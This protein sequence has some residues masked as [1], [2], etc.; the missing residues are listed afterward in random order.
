MSGCEN[1]KYEDIQEEHT[2]I[3]SIYKTDSNPIQIVYSTN[4]NS[5]D[6]SKII[7]DDLKAEFSSGRFFNNEYRFPF[8][9]GTYDIILE[10]HV[11]DTIDR[12][13]WIVL[14]RTVKNYTIEGDVIFIGA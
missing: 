12:D 11:F 10:H 14:S 1:G 3:I 2:Y 7:Y 6:K 4:E 13:S 8:L 9:E 5:G